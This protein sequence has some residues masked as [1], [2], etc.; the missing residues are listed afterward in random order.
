MGTSR[1]DAS[2]STPIWKPTLA[3]LGR[4]DVSIEQQLREVW[5]AAA[6]DRGNA[7]FE[8]LADP[9][10]ASA[11]S[12]ASERLSVERTLAKFDQ[13]N[14]H[15]YKS[16][17]M[18]D[19]ARRALARC[20][21][22]GEGASAFPSELFGEATSYYVSRDL[23][24]LVAARGRVGSIS[25]AIKFKNEIRSVAKDRVKR[26]ATPKPSASAWRRYVAEVLGSLQSK[27]SQK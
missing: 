16:G 5:R 6:R 25:E 18:L 17:L 22:Q 8:S 11:F 15:A 7:L 2:P 21:A 20:A 24:S 23:P 3:I 12:I 14:L 27:E 10:I 4:P 9:S 19:V 13:A 26:I 1:N